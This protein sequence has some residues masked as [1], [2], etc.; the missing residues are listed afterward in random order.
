V[1]IFAIASPSPQKRVLSRRLERLLG[2]ALL[3]ALAAQLAF[4]VRGDGM[5]T[6]EMPYIGC[7][8]RH[9]FHSDYRM[10]PEQPPVAKMLAA[11][12]LALLPVKEPDPPVGDDQ[13][14]WP[15]RFIH[16]VNRDLPIVA[17]ARSAI[18]LATVA[19]ALVLWLVARGLHGDVAG[20]FALALA[21]F[22]PS[23]L[24]HGHLATTDLLSGFSFFICSYAFWAWSRRPGTLAALGV[25]IALGVAVTTRFTASLL[26][27]VFLLLVMPWA[28]GLDTAQRRRAWREVA[29]L[30]VIG[31]A[32]SA[33]VI[34]TVYGFHYAPWPGTSCAQPV[35]PA[36]GVPGQVVASMEAWHVLPEAF[37]EG[38]RFQLEHNRQGHWGYFLGESGSG[39]WNYYLVA[40]LIKNTPGFLVLTALITLLVWRERRRLLRGS[41]ELHWLLP[42]LAVFLIAS[43]ARIQL[44]ERYVLAIYP[45]WILLGAAAAAMVARWRGGLALLAA[46]V[47]LHAVP[48]LSVARRGYLTY[49][50]ALAGGPEGGHRFLA[51]SNLDWGQDL[52]RLAAWMQRRGIP[53]IQLGYF[54]ADDPDRYGID[55]ED[56][57]T[58]GANRPQRPA[59]NPFHGKIAVSAN[60]I[61]GFFFSPADDPYRF[62]HARTPDERVGVFFIYDLP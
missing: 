14:G 9:L 62:L 16:E 7:G 31:A 4:A 15:D 28:V 1:L 10:N 36:L 46:I 21:A 40:F 12:P 19:M 53:R 43:A 34:W 24:A 23:L 2:A 38:L 44:G 49:F 48:T 11:A 45:Y 18:V 59:E 13:I 39:W 56:L 25:G 35:D 8:Y 55:H 3:A 41:P 27:P 29:L 60:L 33:L 37:L 47:V 17:Y 5:T 32:A 52:P 61:L 57:P 54:G 22:H 20:L 58:W 6:D 50:N 30:A 42:A 51:D 26:P